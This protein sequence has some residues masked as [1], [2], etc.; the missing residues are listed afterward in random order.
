MKRL[1]LGCAALFVVA[2]M[3][4]SCGDDDDSAVGIGPD[5]GG[6]DAMIGGS[7]GNADGSGG[8]TMTGGA[9]GMQGGNTTP[10]PAAVRCGAMVCPVPLKTEYNLIAGFASMAGFPLPAG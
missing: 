2:L 10:P 3:V 6:A 1:S 8:R 7:G 5:G 9:G 4:S